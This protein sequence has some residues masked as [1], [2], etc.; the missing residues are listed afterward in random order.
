MKTLP[1]NK[2]KLPDNFNLV[3]KIIIKCILTTTLRTFRL[4]P[5][6]TL[7]RHSK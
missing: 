6:A 7:Q 4:T 1:D 3:V 2:T 5:L